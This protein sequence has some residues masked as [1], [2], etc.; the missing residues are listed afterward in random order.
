MI[1][2]GGRAGAQPVYY[3][4]K[5][6]RSQPTRN[7]MHPVGEWNHIEITCRG[8]LIQIVLNGEKVNSIDLDA[9]TKPNQRPDGTAHKFDQAFKDHPRK[10]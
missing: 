5:E 1:D 10:G 6:I 9:F 7:A 4:Q 8:A 3:I 2:P